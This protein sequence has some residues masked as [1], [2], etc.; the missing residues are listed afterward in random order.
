MRTVDTF[1]AS[2][3]GHF[4]SGP[5]NYGDNLMAS[6]LPALFDVAPRYVAQSRAE[7]IGVG[8]IIDAYHRRKRR[9]QVAPLRRRPWRTLHVWGSGFMN[10]DGLAVW[11]QRLR[12]HAV[13]GP[14]SRGKIAGD[15]PALGDPA[16]LLPLIWA[17]PA[18]RRCAVAVV[19]HFATHAD[20]VA[21]FAGALPRH[22]T[23]VDLLGDPQTVTSEIAAADCVVSSS[24]H[25]LIVADAYGVPLR[26]M[27]AGPQI[28][29]DGF[30]YRDHEAF[31]GTAMQPPVSFE[32]CLANTKN[33]ATLMDA[34]R[35][36]D[37]ATRQALLAAF[38]FR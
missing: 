19:P 35:P 37:E 25:G 34:P 8:S 7:L 36:P 20:F 2:V 23:I 32:D 18:G 14:L 31:R 1:A 30:K 11:P 24:L 33:I 4:G 17:P 10:S 13:R 27:V 3:R 12:F 21:R 9:D 16:L 15:V 6:L 29:G 26:R 5:E 28:K 38:P 22:W